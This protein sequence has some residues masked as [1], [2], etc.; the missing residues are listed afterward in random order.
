MVRDRLK[1][2]AVGSR[3]VPAFLAAAF[4]ANLI[5]VAVGLAAGFAYVSG[6]NGG[7]VA[8][9]RQYRAIHVV[10]ATAWVFLG[11]FA[12]VHAYL[13]GGWPARAQLALWT[14]AGGGCLTGLSMGAYSGREY[15]EAGAVWS[16]PILAGWFCACLGWWRSAGGASGRGAKPVYMYMWPT[17]LALF[18]IAFA[19]AHLWLLPRVGA[20]PLKDLAVQWKSYGTLVGSFNLLVYGAVSYIGCLRAR[21]TEPACTPKAYLLFLVGVFNT[22]ANYGHHTFHVPQTPWVQWAGFLVSAT[23]IVIVF[24]VLGELLAIPPH[25][26]EDPVP[27]LLRWGRF[28]TFTMV[29][30]AVVL[31]V[32][33]INTLAHGTH[34]IM[35]HAMGS[36]IGIDTVLLLAVALELRRHHGLAP[37]GAS[38]VAVR[39]ASLALNGGLA[40]L[41]IVLTMR[42]TAD[43]VLRALGPLAAAPP[44][45]LRL[46]PVAFVA[47]GGVMACALVVLDLEALRR[48]VPALRR[49]R[50]TGS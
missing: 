11:G 8:A 32:P 26:A 13:G 7:I 38:L 9:F 41:M 6:S 34:L 49:P 29:A 12:A 40:A 5:A 50:V 43:A 35:A 4:A 24:A 19:E 46:F 2:P 37:R 16:V 39:L 28:W 23:E 25:D 1:D 36:M 27:G 17:A 20:R 3:S 14:I 31:C 18:V 48:L 44:D 30:L 15:M 47:C 10:F 33:P 45:C 21:S 42:G 22:F